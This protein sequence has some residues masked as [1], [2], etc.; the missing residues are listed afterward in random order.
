VLSKYE[1]RGDVIIKRG[2]AALCANH[3]KITNRP[4]MNTFYTTLVS[5][6]I[7][8]YS[9][10]IVNLVVG[11][12][13]F[14]QDSECTLIS[15]LSPSSIELAYGITMILIYTI[16]L[17]LLKVTPLSYKRKVIIITEVIMVICQLLFAIL[18]AIIIVNFPEGCPIHDALTTVFV[19]TAVLNPLSTATI[20]SLECGG[21][22]S[23]K[24]TNNPVNNN[25]NPPINSGMIG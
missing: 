14:G 22:L 3:N 9:L 7:V 2:E 25:N 18:Q 17:V 24:R 11:S 13:Y 21:C 20:L 12:L 6:L 19:V 1:F 23:H 5:V 10:P 4:G 8:I 15:G 16:C